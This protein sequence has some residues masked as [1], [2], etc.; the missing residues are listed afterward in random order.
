MT[1][2]PVPTTNTVTARGILLETILEKSDVFRNP[3][4][5][6][7]IAD[8]RDHVLHPFD[9]ARLQAV[10]TTTTDAW[11]AIEHSL[12]S[13]PWIE[14]RGS[15]I[16]TEFRVKTYPNTLP[17]NLNDALAEVKNLRTALGKWKDIGQ[18]MIDLTEG[19]HALNLGL[20]KNEELLH[21]TAALAFFYR[22]RIVEFNKARS[23]ESEIDPDP[24]LL[25]AIQADPSKYAEVKILQK[26]FGLLTDEALEKSVEEA[27]T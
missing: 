12:S 6:V 3:D 16:I 1:M 5:W 7:S 11:Q 25:E 19:V 8:F 18:Q 27:S 4:Y 9:L 21:R 24:M 22:S 23:I 20:R 14:T 15:G 10:H 13:F 2:Q 26:S 17:R